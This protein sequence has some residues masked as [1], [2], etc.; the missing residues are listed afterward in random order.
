MILSLVVGL[1]VGPALPGIGALHMVAAIG[2]RPPV[3]GEVS[4]LDDPEDDGLVVDL[5]EHQVFAVRCGVGGSVSAR[6]RCVA[7]KFALLDLCLDPFNEVG[8]LY[9]LG[10][11][12]AAN[13]AAD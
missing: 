6:A 5:L 10:R 12:S 1:L 11:C 2:Q 9:V 4:V 7:C 13:V 3:A 8:N